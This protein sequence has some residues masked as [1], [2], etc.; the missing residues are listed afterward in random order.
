MS[1]KYDELVILATSLQNENKFL[2][3]ELA[4]IQQVVIEK[5]IQLVELETSVN[6]DQQFHKLANFEIHGV[7][8]VTS[9]DA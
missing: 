6:N 9:G 8:K 1:E 4:E 5:D 7:A 2:K 3:D